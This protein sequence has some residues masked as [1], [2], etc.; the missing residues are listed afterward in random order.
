MRRFDLDLLGGDGGQRRLECGSRAVGA[1]GGGG[2]GHVA[3]AQ[4]PVRLRIAVA[5]LV[6]ICI[7]R[8]PGTATLGLAVVVIS[9][10]GGGRPEAG[11][12]DLEIRHLVPAASWGDM[13]AGENRAD[14]RRWRRSTPL[15]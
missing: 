11:W 9:S 4:P 6:L 10:V 14:G 3:V 13:V 15:P 5:L 2:S 7:T 12:S 1:S 8:A